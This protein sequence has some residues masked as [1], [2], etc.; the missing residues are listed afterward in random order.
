MKLDNFS[1]WIGQPN[2]ADT[3]NL[4]NTWFLKIDKEQKMTFSLGN[5]KTK[6]G[7]ISIPLLSEKFIPFLTDGLKQATPEAL[8]ANSDSAGHLVF[9]EEALGF[10]I[11]ISFNPADSIPR[12]FNVQVLH[13]TASILT[14]E[15]SAVNAQCLLDWVQSSGDWNGLTDVENMF[16]SITTYNHGVPDIW[17]FYYDSTTVN[18]GIGISLYNESGNYLNFPFSASNIE[19]LTTYF[20]NPIAPGIDCS[21][22]FGELSWV[23]SYDPSL[24]DHF[25][26]TLTNQT[27][28]YFRPV[29]D[30]DIQALFVW[31]RSTTGIK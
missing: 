23:W 18:K 30:T 21:F 1:V 24:P 7:V 29:S 11:T 27:K 17:A 31:L 16:T 15:L 19:T 9:Q 25:G 6:V 10:Q 2:Y 22:Q 12:N 4:E 5:Y 8:V 28:S 13:E 14:V 3:T 20:E 26:F